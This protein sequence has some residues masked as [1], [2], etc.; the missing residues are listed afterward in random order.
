MYLVPRKLQ[1][2]WGSLCILRDDVPPFPNWVN[3][4]VSFYFIFKPHAV[5]NDLG[6][7]WNHGWGIRPTSR[8][9]FPQNLIRD[10][11]SCK[12]RPSFSSLRRRMFLFGLDDI[13]IN[14]YCNFF[15]SNFLFSI[16][17]VSPVSEYYCL[18]LNC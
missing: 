15:L 6:C 13:H 7:F 8:S 4:Y 12:F 1:R 9:Y 14:R 18:L 16:F 3:P 17:Y 5:E 11:W 10:N 2:K